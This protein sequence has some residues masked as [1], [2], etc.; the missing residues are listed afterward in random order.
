MILAALALVTVSG[1]DGGSVVAPQR[2][3]SVLL[4]SFA[5]SE[6]GSTLAFASVCWLWIVDADTARVLRR[7]RTPEGPVDAM[8]F[9]RDGRT[10]AF[11]TNH[12]P[13]RKDPA[14]TYSWHV[15]STDDDS[16]ERA[17]DVRYPMVFDA[18]IARFDD[19]SRRLLVIN[20][21][22]QVELVDVTTGCVEQTLIAADGDR[23]ASACWWGDERVISCDD[24]GDVQV[25]NARDGTVL[26]TA[27]HLGSSV[28]C[29]ETSL[30]GLRVMTAGLTGSRIDAAAWSL[31]DFQPIALYGSASRLRDTPQPASL[32]SFD[33]LR[34]L[35]RAPTER[36][37]SASLDEQVALDQIDTAE[38]YLADLY[39]DPF[40][41][42]VVS[43]I[44]SCHR[45]AIRLA[46]LGSV[47]RPTALPEAEWPTTHWTGDGRAVVT[48]NKD[49]DVIA[50]ADTTTGSVRFVCYQKPLGDLVVER[51]K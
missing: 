29:V 1:M 50:V 5:T 45:A 51:P 42:D 27:L 15:L 48:I 44:R 8:Q 3:E 41:T 12:A 9:D 22:A 21:D 35:V 20:A 17:C 10:L 24:D 46:L 34:V 39:C 23:I 30:D 37:P 28:R 31:P 7:I 4:R 40:G 47:G 14:C 33:T 19:T 11:R 36:A 13:L 32:H 43:E 38:T 49:S 25:W 2:E 16:P 26:W 18:P 6:R